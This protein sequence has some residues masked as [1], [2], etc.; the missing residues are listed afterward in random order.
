MNN[1]FAKGTIQPM[2]GQKR[3]RILVHSV[4]ED[5]VVMILMNLVMMK[6]IMAVILIVIMMNKS[7]L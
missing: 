4:F 7:L 6:L 5:K 1:S 3:R 2:G